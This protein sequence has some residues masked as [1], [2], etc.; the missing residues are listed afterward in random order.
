M[1]GG[2]LAGFA[3]FQRAKSA[4]LPAGDLPDGALTG[5]PVAGPL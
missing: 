2:L 3:L 4:A 5:P 1:K